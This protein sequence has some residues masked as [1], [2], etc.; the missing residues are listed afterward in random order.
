MFLTNRTLSFQKTRV[1]ETGISD[2]HKLISTFLKPCCTRLKQK[3]IYYRN[4]KNFNEELFLKDLENLNLSANP[5]KLH[6]NYINL[7]QKSPKVVQKRALLK[8]KIHR[9]N[10]APFINREFGKE[11]YKQSR[12]R[13]KFWK[14]PSKENELLFKTQRNEYVSLRRSCIKSYFQDVTKKALV[15]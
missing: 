5:D 15:T 6:E 4:Y 13:N 14:D 9:G 1:T 2:Y 12:F 8:G 7:L 3:I 11:I 10:H